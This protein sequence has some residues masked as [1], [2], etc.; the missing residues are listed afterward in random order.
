M[1]CAPR[2]TREPAKRSVRQLSAFTLIE[3]I[4]VI[5]VLAIL[6]AVAVPRYFN[7]ADDAERAVAKAG[8]AS[9]VEAINHW[10]LAAR[11]D[12]SMGGPNPPTPA[13]SLE[14]L[15]ALA[16]LTPWYE[17]GDVIFNVDNGSVNKW[18]PRYKTVSAGR[19]NGWGLIWYNPNN[20]G[21][22]FRVPDQGSDQA[23]L[24]YYNIVNQCSLSRLSSTSRQ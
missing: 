17:P 19:S 21:V 1:A 14:S 9:L 2:P 15:D 23:T 8:R 5:V 22:R 7:Y 3:L 12:P 4:A 6:A 18:H 20:A 24:E 10:Q 13:A 16:Q 11:L